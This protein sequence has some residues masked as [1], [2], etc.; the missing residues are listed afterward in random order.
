MAESA[1]ELRRYRFAPLD[2]S[3]VMLGLSLGQCCM[4]GTGILVS[5]FT[6]RIAPPVVAAAPVLVASLVAFAQLHGRP[7]RDWIPLYVRWRRNARQPWRVAVSDLALASGPQLPP[8]LEGLELVEVDAPDWVRRCRVG[9]VGVLF[10]SRA[11]RATAVVAVSGCE[12]SLAEASEQDRS[13]AAWG[14][15]LA[16]FSRERSPVSRVAWTE[17]AAP[18]GVDDHLAYVRKH[19][20]SE[21]PGR[22]AYLALV[23]HAR[24]FA[25][26]HQV[27]VAI[28]VDQ[29]RMRSRRAA[30]TARDQ[31]VAVLLDEVRLFAQ[32]AV[33][34][35]LVVEAPLRPDALASTIR[36]RLVGGLQSEPAG[37]RSFG[38]LALVH[39][40]DHVQID[41]TYQRAYWIAQWPRLEQGA[42]WMAPLLL[43]GGG[44]RA[45]AMVYSPVPI[46]RSTRAVARD[47]VKLTA[48]EDQRR[49]GGWRI[50]AAQ[51]RAHH[52]VTQREAELVAGYAELQYAGFIVVSESSVVALDERCAELEQLA[53]RVGL[54]LRA[55]YG[56][57]DVGVAA[58]L[59]LGRY[60]AAQWRP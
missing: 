8:M 54:E 51:R 27:M 43:H 39:R 13:V 45:I 4:L 41:G 38:P 57:H 36:N 24:E 44:T 21:A 31:M 53:A 40:F 26:H 18:A 32:R 14:E 7:L 25:A 34:V 20:A 52:E 10:D 16:V 2:R 33:D 50:G 49:R 30:G 48:D 22:A 6:M 56:Q 42:D 28:T 55:L 11:R 1:L 59:P 3:G 60:P 5:A 35:G 37:S 17:W 19:G 46:S 12:F 58:T 9:G 29:R 47:A 15:V 23:D